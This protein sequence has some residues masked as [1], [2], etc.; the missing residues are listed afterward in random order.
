VHYE[1]SLNTSFAENAA[2]ESLFLLETWYANRLNGRQ[3]LTPEIKKTKYIHLHLH[4]KP[5]A[6]YANEQEKEV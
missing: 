2:T 3:L 5:S 4:L 1:K 6:K